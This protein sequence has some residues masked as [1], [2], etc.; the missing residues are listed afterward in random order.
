MPAAE[1]RPRMALRVGVTGKRSLTSPKAE[2]LRPRIATALAAIHLTLEEEVASAAGAYSGER[3]IMRAVSPL[4]EGADRLFAEEAVQLGYELQVP[5][6]FERGEYKKD[7]GDEAS[8]RAFDALLAKAAAVFDLQGEVGPDGQHL[9]AAY[10]ELG[11]VVLDHCDVLVAIWDGLPAA[12]KGGTAHVIGMARERHIPVLCFGLGSFEDTLFGSDE[13]AGGVPLEMR[14]VKDIATAIVRPPWLGSENPQDPDSNGSYLADG[15]FDTPLLGVVWS[16]FV[17]LMRLGVNLEDPRPELIQ[18]SH[19]R[20]EYI[21]VDAVANRLAGL[22]RGSFLA[23]YGLGLCAVLYALLGYADGR[24]GVFWL[25]SEL[26]AIALVL[27]LNLALWK[28]RWHFRSVDCRYLA[29]Q[30]R[31]LCYLHPLGLAAPRLRLPAHHLNADV[32]RSWMEWRLRAM[33]REQPLPSIVWTSAETVRYYKEVVAKWTDGQRAYH[34]RNEKSLETIEARLT[35]LGWAA[36]IAA[37]LACL[38]HFRFHDPATAAWLTLCAAW[39]PALAAAC[40]AIATQG[41]F[42]R[43]SE[44]SEAMHRT[45]DAAGNRLKEASGSDRFSAAV[46]RRES[47]ALAA[48]MMEEVVDWQI[49]YR[50]P[51]PPG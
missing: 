3:P 26:A 48:L 7:F 38:L 47:E 22:Y 23:N 40:H 32:E 2:T 14:Q 41:E 28:K 9:P 18:A 12:G 20:S 8:C 25:W 43:L 11:R 42:R 37:A 19:F 10:E 35:V 27:V 13:R 17:K 34:R 46:L 39:F 5:L 21:R 44:R 24:R 36:V 15:R 45:L 33:V 49:L 4:A 16:V 6:P 29:E 31:I 30:L 51:V 1:S 50:K